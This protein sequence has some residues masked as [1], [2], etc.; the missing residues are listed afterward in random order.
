MLKFRGIFCPLLTPFD[1]RGELYLAKVRHN[2]GRLNQTTLAGYVVSGD[3]GEAPLLTFDE[4]IRLFGEVRG[5]AAEGRMLIADVSAPSVHETTLLAKEAADAGYDCVFVG[6]S[7]LMG[8]PRVYFSTVAD[9]SQLPVVAGLGG[10]Q[11]ELGAHPNVVAVCCPGSPDD[12]SQLRAALPDRVQLLTSSAPGMVDCFQA[13]ATAAILPL[14]NAAPFFLLSIEE[15]IRTREIAAAKDLAA[16]A[17]DL[18]SA[19]AELGAGGL[20]HAADL[21]G[22]YGGRPRL[23]L[24]SAGP[25]AQQRIAKA[26][27]E[28]AG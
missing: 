7:R 13:G 17:A 14:T 9:R 28:V 4:R 11:G 6:G 19:V 26:L 10:D 3:A 21:R 16:I 23:P 24:E 2:V 22:Y 8:N 20:K 12:V 18:V 5:Q 15:A 27:E 1:H 25:E